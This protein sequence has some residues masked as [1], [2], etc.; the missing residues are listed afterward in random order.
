M[1]HVQYDHLILEYVELIY[2][3]RMFVEIDHNHVQFYFSQLIKIL[4]LTKFSQKPYLI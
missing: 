4:N 3:Y 2:E 1:I